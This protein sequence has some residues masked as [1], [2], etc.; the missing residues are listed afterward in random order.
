MQ[1]VKNVIQQARGMWRDEMIALAKE[2]WWERNRR[3]LPHKIAKAVRSLAAP[4][5]S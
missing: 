3:T 1:E 5:R 4:R 2:V